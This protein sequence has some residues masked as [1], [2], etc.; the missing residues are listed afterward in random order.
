MKICFTRPYVVLFLALVLGN[1][2]CY[3]TSA[4]NKT[5]QSTNTQDGLHSPVFVGLY[6]GYNKMKG[7]YHSDG[8]TAFYRFALGLNAGTVHDLSFAFEAG[9]QSGNTLRIKT[10]E[11][12][13]QPTGG[14]MP[15]A[16]LKPF[17]DLLATVRYSIVEKFSILMKLG[18]AYRELH[19]NDR[20][21]TGDSLKKFNFELQAGF[22][23]QITEAARFVVLYQQLFC[24]EHG[25][26]TLNH[27]NG[28]MLHQIPSQLGGLLGI[29]L[30]F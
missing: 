6:G 3:A 25:K 16:T 28:V 13:I 18:A 24:S 19:F 1:I 10:R 23:Y 14:L 15:Q 17:I 2:P 11:G 8:Q 29:E 9:V 21:S 12:V 30:G 5:N 7:A 26:L 27:T 20:T 22:G 4:P